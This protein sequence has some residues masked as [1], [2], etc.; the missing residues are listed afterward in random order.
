VRYV[1]DGAGE[2]Y[3]KGSVGP[4]NGEF[5]F[6]TTPLNSK[7]FVYELISTKFHMKVALGTSHIMIV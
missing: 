7:I 2:K 1:P 5:Q 6:F 4:K 3:E